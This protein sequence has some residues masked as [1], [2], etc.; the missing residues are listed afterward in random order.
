MSID[1]GNLRISGKYFGRLPAAGDDGGKG[2]IIYR[3]FYWKR[4]DFTGGSVIN[5]TSDMEVGSFFYAR[6]RTEEDHANENTGGGSCARKD[7]IGLYGV[8]TA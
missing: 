2:G 8:Q 6:K 5:W 4:L 7:Y 1:K 3:I